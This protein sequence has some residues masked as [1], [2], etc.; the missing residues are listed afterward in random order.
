MSMAAEAR[1]SPHPLLLDPVQHA[2]V[3]PT[4]LGTAAAAGASFHTFDS[5][6]F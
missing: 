5:K 3:V 4:E 6:E 1:L 2:G